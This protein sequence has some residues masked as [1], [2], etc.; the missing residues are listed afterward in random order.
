MELLSFS[1]IYFEFT[2]SQTNPIKIYYPF[3]EF[4][5]LTFLL[6][7]FIWRILYLSINH[8][9]NSILNHYLF[10]E[11]TLNSLFFE[12]NYYIS[13]IFSWF[14]Y[15]FHK[16]SISYAK[17]LW[18]HFFSRI[19]Y[20]FTIVFAITYRSIIIS[21]NS[22][23]FSRFTIDPFSIPRIDY[24]FTIIF[25][26]SLLFSRFT[27]DPFSF[28]RIDYIFTIIFA[29]SL[30]FSRFSMDPFWFPRIDYIFTNIFANSLLFSRF[31]MDPLFFSRIHFTFTFI[32][33]IL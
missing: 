24:I 14:H 8:F 11:L 7:L 5:V 23:L 33:T 20:T 32:C 22:L 12:R 26:N 30:L 15:L 4:T 10:R 6:S 21:V 3:R 17:T 25:A 9:L 27:M 29:N 2:T 28:P 31:T 16:F 1:R 18:I 19:H 13:I